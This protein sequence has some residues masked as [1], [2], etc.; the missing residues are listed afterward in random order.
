MRGK[1]SISC[2]C[3]EERDFFEAALETRSLPLIGQTE[4]QTSLALSPVERV[5]FCFKINI[6]VGC[7]K[8]S[9]LFDNSPYNQE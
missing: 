3:F 9:S 1:C 4:P 5:L 6:G 2:S 7:L 8:V